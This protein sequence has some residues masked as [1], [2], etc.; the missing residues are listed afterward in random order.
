M[1]Q[2]RP[3]NSEHKNTKFSAVSLFWR[4]LQIIFQID[5]KKSAIFADRQKAC[6]FKPKIISIS[7]FIDIK[8]W[9]NFIPN[10]Y[11]TKL[12]PFG[13]ISVFLKSSVMNYSYCPSTMFLLPRRTSFSR[14]SVA[15]FK[16]HNKILKSFRESKILYESVGNRL[17]VVIK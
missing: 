8:Y 2:Y 5:R 12:T 10:V 4:K 11:L 16:I 14:F 9:F 13:N 6:V 7:K 17:L 3:I 15:Y 1:S